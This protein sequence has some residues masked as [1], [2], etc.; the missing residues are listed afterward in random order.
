MAKRNTITE[1]KFND[2]EYFVGVIDM[3]GIRIGMVGE[4]CF[5]IPLGHAWH[6]RV[7]E[8]NTRS[9]VEDLFDELFEHIG[10]L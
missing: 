4:Q 7:A 6:D 9:E 5:D 2:G 10:V 3:P 1:M 8:A